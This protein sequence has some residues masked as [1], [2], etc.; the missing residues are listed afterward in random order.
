MAKL[1]TERGYVF[2]STAEL[3]IVKD[4]K[5]KTCFVALDYEAAMK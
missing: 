2:K 1:L 4:I 3:E 5:E